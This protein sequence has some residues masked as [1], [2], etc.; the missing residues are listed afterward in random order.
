MDAFKILGIANNASRE[1]IDA[2][3]REQAKRYHPDIGGDARA[4]KQVQEAYE[5]LTARAASN[6]LHAAAGHHPAQR[7]ELASEVQLQ[8]Q[9][10]TPRK[11]GRQRL[12]SGKPALKRGPSKG[13]PQRTPR[14][15]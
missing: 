1:D 9:N 7:H 6:K 12:R 11:L 10:S 13:R 5:M 14:T 8:G 4:F 3:Y 2:A 15:N